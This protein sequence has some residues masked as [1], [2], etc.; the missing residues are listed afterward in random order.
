MSDYTKVNYHDAD[1]RNGMYFL[2]DE[3]D[4]ENMGVTVVECDPGWEGKEHAH[5]E[6]G[7]EE[8]YLLMEGEA[9]VT[10]EDESI[11][12]NPGDAIRIAPDTTHRIHNGDTESRFVLMGA[13]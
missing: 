13:P 6:E 10:V 12:M 7:H 5:E 8:V 2:R 3:L 4:C 9:T 11:E 1:D